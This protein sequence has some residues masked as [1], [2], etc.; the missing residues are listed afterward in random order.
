M[1]SKAQRRGRKRKAA[2][3]NLPG[4]TPQESN[5]YPS[6]KAKPEDP[7]KTA[8]HARCRRAGISDPKE[9]ARALLDG[10][11]GYCID[12]LARPDELADLSRLWSEIRNS[13]ENYC[14]R[15]LG[16]KATAQGSAIAMI[17]E[18]VETDPSLRVDLRTPEEKAVAAKASWMGWQEKIAALPVPNMKW[19]LRGALNGFMGEDSL[20]RDCA[21]TTNG[22]LAVH[23]LRLLVGAG[24]G[25]MTARQ[26]VDAPSRA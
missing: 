21:P 9:A 3:V 20:W 5:R 11:M 19:A 10:E 1:T 17:P 12:A 22:R 26:G 2:P 18:K 24:S 13:R 15:Y 23:A 25:K 6:G 8:L 7:R 14:L 16:R 4:E